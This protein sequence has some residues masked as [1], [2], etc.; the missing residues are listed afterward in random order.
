MIPVPY[1]IQPSW[2]RMDLALA[3]ADGCGPAALMDSGHCGGVRLRVGRPSLPS[4]NPARCA[5]RSSAWLEKEEERMSRKPGSSEN[6]VASVNESESEQGTVTSEDP[7]LRELPVCE[8]QLVGAPEVDPELNKGFEK[9]DILTK[10]AKQFPAGT[11]YQVEEEAIDESGLKEVNKII[12]SKDLHTLGETECSL[13]YKA[14]IPMQEAERK[15]FNVENG[16]LVNKDD[17]APSLKNGTNLLSPGL[18]P[19]TQNGSFSSFSVTPSENNYSDDAI[20]HAEKVAVIQYQDM[21]DQDA[22]INGGADSGH[23]AE[24]EST[25]S[26]A[27]LTTI[28][29]EANFV[30]RKYDAEKKA[31]KLFSD[32]EERK[33]QTVII[34]ETAGGAS[35]EKERREIIK[36]QAMKKSTT[37]AEKQVSIKPLESEEKPSLDVSTHKHEESQLQMSTENASSVSF[38]NG[39]PILEPEGINTEQ[40]NF[41]AARQQFLQMERSRQE[42]PTCPM[43]SAQSHRVLIQCSTP[44]ESTQPLQYKDG[45]TLDTSPAIMVKAVRVDSVHEDEKDDDQSPKSPMNSLFTAEKIAGLEDNDGEKIGSMRQNLLACSSIDDLDSGLGEMSNDYSYGF[46]GDCG[47]SNEM[48]NLETDNSCVFECSEQKLKAETPIEKEIRLALEREEILRKERGIRKSASSEKMVQIKTK[49]LLTQ[50]PPTSPFSKH[51]DK[52]RMVFFV[53]REIEMES[54]RE[55]KLKEEG[56]I[57]GLYDKGMPQEVEE[58]KKV[59]EQQT[60]DVPVIPQLGWQSKLARSASQEFLDVPDVPE[61]SNAVQTDSTE[62]KE[63]LQEGSENQPYTLRP[64]KHQ[65]NFLIEREIEEIQQREEELLRLRKQTAGTLPSTPASI[66]ESQSPEWTSRAG[67][68]NG[69]QSKDL[70]VTHGQE[71][72]NPKPLGKK[73]E[74]SV[75]ESTRVTRRK[76]AMAQRWEAGLFNNH[77]DE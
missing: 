12:L 33:Y 76:N 25:E 66:S 74:S 71:G 40:I 62:S 57:K 20:I 18:N 54:K 34:T 56:K 35:L 2:K 10:N 39:S 53:Q 58:R 55:E 61:E 26:G 50:L 27:R 11:N 17:S 69:D 21:D 32:D 31:T 59:F 48:L 47:A 38:H 1:A 15:A 45:I 6:Q 30:L 43:L 51:K 65:T 23:S 8:T 52:N 41:T 63:L 44:S 28:K 64:W 9:G 77:Q 7:V 37:I 42:V 70:P 24:K 60:D 29:K 14:S 49:P 46:T 13:G 75:L 5:S 67:T 3:E 4:R 36:N 72:R 19:I 22:L 16:G 68:S 73:D